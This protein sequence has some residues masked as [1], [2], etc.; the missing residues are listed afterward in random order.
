VDD[1]ATTLSL[2]PDTRYKDTRVYDD[3]GV[4]SFALLEPPP[5]LVAAA[6]DIVHMVQEHE[7]GFL[8]KIAANY[9]GTGYEKL[10]WVIALVNGV[11]DAETELFPGA[12]IRI[13][14]RSRV[15]Q[16]LMRA[17]RA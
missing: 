11:I 13:P 5:E 6:D 3:D 9:Y 16:F 15:V 12:R 14:Q 7:V 10:W 1:V 17:G 2:R 4:V 8:D